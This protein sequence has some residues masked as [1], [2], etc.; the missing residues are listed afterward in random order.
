VDWI[1]T[2]HKAV[3]DGKLKEIASWTANAMDEGVEPSRIVNEALVP[4][5]NRVAELW[6]EETY[7]IPEV[8]R[9]AK[10]MQAG[11]EVLKPHLVTTD[12]LKPTKV[13][14]GTVKG[15][16]HDIGKNLVSIMLQGVG[17]PVEDLGV[18]VPAERFLQAAR[19]GAG[20][21]GLSSLLTT[22]MPEMGNVVASL[23]SAGLRDGVT[24]IVGGAPVTQEFAVRI[25]ADL[26]AKDAAEAVQILKRR[27]G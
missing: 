23:R 13:A 2:L 7:F 4:A 25:G 24:V 21:I 19:E 11:M 27:F 5:M 10:T 15:D 20:V 17:Y 1:E 26:Y 18:D 3:V 22:T 6:Q 14:V 12:L 9:S 8:L 16:R